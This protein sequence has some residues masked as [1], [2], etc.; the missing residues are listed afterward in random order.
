MIRAHARRGT[1]P[2]LIH[3]PTPI[4]SPAPNPRPSLG[5]MRPTHPRN[6]AATLLGATLLGA[7][8]LTT[9]SCSTTPPH[10]P[11]TS[12]PTHIPIP[13]AAPTS[14]STTSIAPYD[15]L[16]NLPPD[17][18][19]HTVKGAEAFARY[20]FEASSKVV[21]NPSPGQFSRLCAPGAL[22]CQWREDKV[23]ALLA[24][25]QRVSGPELTAP[26]AVAIPDTPLPDQYAYITVLIH[27]LPT[28]R[29]DITGADLGEYTPRGTYGMDIKLTWTE[30]GWRALQVGDPSKT[31]PEKR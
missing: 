10:A 28:R 18:K 1:A 8:V 4:A 29:L 21:E 22:P 9:N 20:F 11:T 26:Q 6:L 16:A 12:T 7:G 3:N 2:G 17:A 25:G 14:A 23:S 5:I 27:Q 13:T 15:V 19:E 30:D 24:K 31:K